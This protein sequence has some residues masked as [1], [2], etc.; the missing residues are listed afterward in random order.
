MNEAQPSTPKGDIPHPPWVRFGLM[1]SWRQAALTFIAIL[2]LARVWLLFVAPFDLGPDEAQYWSWSHDFSFGY[3]SK[4]PMLAWV[5]GA[6]TAACGMGEACVRLGSPFFHG[7]TALML[8]LLARNMFDDRVGFWTSILYATLPGVWFSS[9]L[10]TTDV[11][12]L[13]FWS[14]S[15]VG[16]WFLREERALKW[17]IVLG[18]GIGLGFMSKYA[19][20]Y[21]LIGGA[22]AS[23]IDKQ[24]RRAILS[25]YGAIAGVIGLALFAPN[26][27]W[28]STHDFST[29]THTA[30]NANWGADLFNLDEMLDFIGGQFAIFGPFLFG[31]LV[32]AL[33]SFV[34]MARRKDSIDFRLLWLASFAVPALSVGIVQ[35]F[36]SRANAN[37]AATAYVAATVLVVAWLLKSRAKPLLPASF[38]LHNVFGLLLV[39]VVIW[40]SLIVTLDRTNDFKRVRGWE[41]IGKYV[42]VRA[43]GGIDGQPY[44]AVLVNDRLTYGELLYY[45]PDMA[46]PLTMWDAN[47]VPENHFELMDPF[48]ADLDG[49]VLIVARGNGAE[50]IASAFARARELEPLSVQIG[51]GRTRDYRLFVVNDYQGI[52]AQ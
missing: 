19:M 25:P 48:T 5:I 11:P 23:I 29:L 35:G 15:L 33:V 51:G 37:W 24:T 22:L 49:N 50:H 40:P 17:A 10:I 44:T 6:T 52:P 2:T 46:V 13:F 16:L 43:N 21:F 45:A 32:F 28:N 7:F 34:M 26:L 8:F 47:G 9:G 36:I 20:V 14:L 27:W 41:E 3:F 38:I 42:E 30:A 4:P 12:L 39:A 18:V 1:L 31:A